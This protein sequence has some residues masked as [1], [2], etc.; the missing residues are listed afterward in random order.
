MPATQ[1]V[2]VIRP[3]PTTHGSM[4]DAFIAFAIKY[5]Y[6]MAGSQ[7]LT[8]P[9]VMRPRRMCRSPGQNRAVEDPACK[10][11]SNAEGQL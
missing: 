4:T 5:R 9:S 11:G 6:L 10:C 8:P 3:L 7:L 1:R 2:P